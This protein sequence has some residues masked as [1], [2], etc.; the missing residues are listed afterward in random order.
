VYS[1]Y[2]KTSS[3]TKTAIRYALQLM[4]L[5]E[6]AI[7][8]IKKLVK[9]GYVAYFAGGYVRDLLM[10]HPSSDIDIATD[11]PPEKI[12]DLFSHTI[13]VGLAFGVIV[14][15]V[16]GHAFEVSTFRKDI[17]YL[18]GRSPESI[19]L[20]SPR[21]DAIRRDF[22]INGLFYDPLEDSIYDYV[23]GREDIQKGIIRAIGDPGERFLEDKLR[24]IRAVR[25]SAR[26]GFFIDPVTEEGI[27]ENAESLFPAVAMERIAQEFNKMK[28]SGRFL[29]SIIE[30]HRLSLLE[31]VFPD[32]KGVHL[33]DIKELAKSFDRF[34]KEVPAIIYLME[35][36]PKFQL[37]DF[38]D[39]CVYLKL[40]TAEAKLVEFHYHYRNLILNCEKMDKVD[41]VY[42]Y[43]HA[44]SLASLQ[45]AAAHM[46]KKQGDLF[47]EKHQKKIQKLLPHILRIQNKTPL[48]NGAILKQHGILEGKKMGIL[49]KE[50]ERFSIEHDLHEPIAL[51]EVLKKSKNWM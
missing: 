35:L 24:M 21:E 22:T 3:D 51:L 31:V 44:F 23:G 11:A 18:N 38:L 41:L 36:F 17:S 30:M 19:E 46:E 42:F 15:V 26:F 45:I 8:I 40:S 39:L 43:A 14:V 6:K 33:T 29:Q 13:P 49:L 16:E 1:F 10:G 5:K 27:R 20:S 9:E 48:I 34:P 7:T 12:L 50:A 2:I 37:E 28:D 4:E 32:L 25:F 47:L